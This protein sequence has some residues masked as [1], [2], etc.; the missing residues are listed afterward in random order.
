MSLDARGAPAVLHAIGSSYQ[1][2]ALLLHSC[3]PE[4]VNLKKVGGQTLCLASE[5]NNI[6][7]VKLLLEKGVHVDDRGD[8]K[9]TPL[10]CAALAGHADMA[11]LLLRSGAKPDLQG[12]CRETALHCASAAGFL[13]VV[14]VLIDYQARVTVVL[15]D[16]ST[17]LHCAAGNLHK[18]FMEFLLR[19]GAEASA[20]NKSGLQFA[21]V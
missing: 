17:A 8:D 21:D 1:E 20:R 12:P 7:G 6:D 4:L 15:E 13:E 16:G 3:G 9:S 5:N 11:M 19:N 18:E 2:I 10:M 14:K